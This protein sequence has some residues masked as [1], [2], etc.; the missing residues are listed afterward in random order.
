MGERA[1]TRLPRAAGPGLGD[2]DDQ[3]LAAGPRAVVAPGVSILDTSTDALPDEQDGE[4][5]DRGNS[6][7]AGPAA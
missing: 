2:P 6:A 7:P 5:D 4:Q 1:G 3:G